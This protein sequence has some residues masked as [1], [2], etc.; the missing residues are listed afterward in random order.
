V[1]YVLYLCG[2]CVYEGGGETAHFHL[3]ASGWE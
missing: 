1:L 3:S 2:V